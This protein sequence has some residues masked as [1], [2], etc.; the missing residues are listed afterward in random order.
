MA[1]DV[2]RQLGRENPAHAKE[3]NVNPGGIFAMG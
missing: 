3:G 1:A 2:R